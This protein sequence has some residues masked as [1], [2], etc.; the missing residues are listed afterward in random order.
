MADYQRR[1]DAVEA[2]LAAKVSPPLVVLVVGDDDPAEAIAKARLKNNW[3]DDGR[4]RVDVIHVRGVSP[5]RLG[6]P[7]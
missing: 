7:D 1:L 6:L 5:G 4:H 3:P 2:M